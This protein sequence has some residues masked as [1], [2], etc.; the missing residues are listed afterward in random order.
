MKNP[1]ENCTETDDKPI[2]FAVLADGNFIRGNVF[3]SDDEARAAMLRLDKEFPKVHRKI[4]PLYQ[5]S[6][7]V[8]TRTE[9]P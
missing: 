4:L 9:E 6:E 8:S 1:I 2:A 3:D 5:R 7:H